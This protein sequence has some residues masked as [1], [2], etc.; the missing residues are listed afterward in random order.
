MRTPVIP[1]FS[2]YD[3]QI[4]FGSGIGRRCEGQLC[5]YGILRTEGEAGRLLE[6]LGHRRADASPKRHLQDFS[7]EQFDMLQWGR[8]QLIAETELS[9]RYPLW[10]KELQCGRDQLIA[11]TR[12]SISMRSYTSR[13]QWGRD[14][15][16]AETTDTDGIVPSHFWLQWGRDQLIAETCR[17][18]PV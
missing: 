5:A 11:E 10:V 8:D 3:C 15:L 14:Q 2:G 18:A 12:P 4:G 6:K 16:I 13:L 17:L 1:R 9:A 7:V